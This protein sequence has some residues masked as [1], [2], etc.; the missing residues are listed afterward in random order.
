MNYQPNLSTETPTLEGI[1][2]ISLWQTL[3]RGLGL[4]V[5]S[6]PQEIRNLALINVVTAW[7]PALALLFSKT[8]IDQCV[9][10]LQGNAVEN[11]LGLLL[12]NPLLLWSLGI[13]L[14]VNLLADLLDVVETMAFI[15]LRDR[16]EGSIK[17][18]VLTK[19]AYFNDLA[20]FET[21]ELLNLVQLT[22]KGVQRLQ[23]L[24][25]ILAFTLFG[26]FRLLPAILLSASIGFWVLAVLLV[27]GI[28]SIGVELYYRKR[29]WRTEA[30]QVVRS[31]EKDIY[32]RMI[33]GEAY[34]KEIR[35][36]SLQPVL[37]NHWQTLWDSIFEDMQTI[38]QRSVY[39][40]ILWAFVGG[41]GTA[42]PYF[43][44][45]I[46]VLQGTYT[47]GDLALYMGIIL[48]LRQSLFL[49]ISQ[50][51]DLYDV[52][53]AAKPVF[54]ILDLEPQLTNNPTPHPD[55]LSA[56]GVPLETHAD[57]GVTPAVISAV[58]AAV[59][60]AI[61]LPMVAPLTLSRVPPGVASLVPIPGIISPMAGTIPHLGLHIE[62]LSFAYPGC[63]RPTLNNLNLTIRSGEM[64]ALVGENG[65]GKTTLAKLLCRLYDPQQGA[66]F[67]Q[68]QDLRK[69][70][71]ETL[72]SHITF[73]MQDYARFPA[74][75]RQNVGWGHLPDLYNDLAIHQAL[76]QAGLGEFV[77]QLDQQLETPLGKQLASGIDL[78]GGQ[79][80]RVAIARALLRLQS[81]PLSSGLLLFDEPTA[82]LDPKH[83]Q[84]IYSLL[85]T[86]AQGRVTLV[87]SHRL[88]LAKMADR[89]VVLQQGT[90]LEQDTHDQLMAQPSL[91]RTLFTRQA[92]SYI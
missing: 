56:P 13:T 26:V 72:R 81:Q 80:Q 11:G 40:V 5:R 1:K 2:D 58:T 60:P 19:I 17:Q 85:K 20:L 77:A 92:S 79:W 47:L 46:G 83:E 87:I 14:G 8:I 52:L 28:P 7:G 32:D 63:D 30:L 38:R 78:S 84:E 45:V 44:I 86:I 71:L 67:W 75:L 21:P 48:Q 41:V 29:T 37:L 64:V 55:S 62:N 25:N 9:A 4:V 16:V 12:H 43:S 59:T 61:T 22:E 54:Q 15:T 42:V 69:W 24:A 88:A 6:A 82:A 18:L 73:V 27:S 70:D 89:I 3:R 65:A 35:L 76:A 68:G 33:R 90:V 91:Y 50:V 10:I 34:A 31:R 53:L 23:R 36:F 39:H 57:D 51:G 74:T 49:I 66:I